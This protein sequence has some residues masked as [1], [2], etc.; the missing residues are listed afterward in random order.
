MYYIDNSGYKKC[1]FNISK[2]EFYLV[3]ERI[4]SL[5]NPLL[6]LI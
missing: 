2:D 6:N 4:F 5:V 3:T 1:I